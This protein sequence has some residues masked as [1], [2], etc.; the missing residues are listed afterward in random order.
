MLVH[1][2]INSTFQQ[3]CSLPPLLPL[4]LAWCDPPPPPPPLGAVQVHLRHPGGV[5]RL[6]CLA[7]PRPGALGQAQAEV[8][9]GQ[10]LHEAP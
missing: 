5:C 2:E 6:R 9:Q 3:A 7:F 1:I 4:S 8:T 10:D